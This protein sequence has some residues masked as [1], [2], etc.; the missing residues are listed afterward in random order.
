MQMIKLWTN[1]DCLGE[2]RFGESKISHPGAWRARGWARKHLRPSSHGEGSAT[3]E[4]EDT[5]A[6]AAERR[7]GGCPERLLPSRHCGEYCVGDAEPWSSRADLLY[8]H[9]RRGGI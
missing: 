8:A 4:G 1:I 7:R 9:R 6:A 3:W 5:A 2:L